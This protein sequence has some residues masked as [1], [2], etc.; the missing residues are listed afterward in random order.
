MVDEGGGDE[1]GASGEQRAHRA[2]ERAMLVELW[3]LRFQSSAGEG[4]W[5][6]RVNAGA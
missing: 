4:R 1:D 2:E 3:E 5:T 6:N